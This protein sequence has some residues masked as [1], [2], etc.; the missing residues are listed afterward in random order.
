MNVITGAEGVLALAGR[1]GVGDVARFLLDHVDALKNPDAGELANR[2]GDVLDQVI[3]GFGIGAETGLAL[4]GVGQV[5]LGNPMTA[6][7]AAAVATNPVAM[8]CAAVGA[9]YYGWSALRDH[10]REAALT[11]VGKAF[12][13][14]SELVRAVVDLALKLLRQLASFARELKKWVA[15]ATAAF[16]G[17]LSDVTRAFSDRALEAG[18]SAAAAVNAA[19]LTAKRLLPAKLNTPG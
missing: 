16:G 15:E 18:R 4:I 9:V 3:G 11:L 7:S 14:G 13:I 6:A 12:G 19:A 10:E 8:T 1:Y 17:S 2:C 5:L